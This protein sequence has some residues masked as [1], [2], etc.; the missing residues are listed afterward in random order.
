MESELFE[1]DEEAASDFLAID[2][3]YCLKNYRNENTSV[4]KSYNYYTQIGLL[5]TSSRHLNVVES[6]MCRAVWKERHGLNKMSTSEIIALS[7]SKEERKSGMKAPPGE[8]T[9]MEKYHDTPQMRR[10]K[11]L[12]EIMRNAT[13]NS[14]MKTS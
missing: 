6:M 2:S 11:K 3:G 4:T 13:R 5:S 8:M 9:L 1:V 12:N 14:K 7:I 10:L